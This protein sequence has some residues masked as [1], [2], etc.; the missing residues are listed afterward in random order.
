M[1]SIRKKNIK[2]LLVN[3]I[4]LLIVSSYQLSLEVD[5]RSFMDIDCSISCG[6][7][8]KICNEMEL[9]QGEEI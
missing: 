6:T 8:R 2:N 5:L 4:S 7:R 1:F 3:L 9:K